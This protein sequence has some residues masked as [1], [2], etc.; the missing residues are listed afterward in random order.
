MG[1][2]TLFLYAKDKQELLLLVFDD[3]IERLI[4]EAFATLPDHATL[5][6]E[7]VHIFGHFFQ[8]YDHDSETARAYV[9]VLLFHREAQGY[10]RQAAV[11]L[12]SFFERL[13]GRVVRAKASGEVGQHVDEAQAARNFF[14]LYSAALLTWLSGIVGIEEALNQLLRPSLELQVQG[15][16][17]R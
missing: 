11:Q 10:R 9:E 4:E 6:D 1:T 16:L 3:A 15:L 13:A 8:F 17:P 7:L 14:A 2:G 12:D 5:L